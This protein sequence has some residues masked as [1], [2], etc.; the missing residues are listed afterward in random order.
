LA[1]IENPPSVGFVL[2]AAV[3]LTSAI[4]L[5]EYDVDAFLGAGEY[6]VDGPFG[7][8]CLGL[9]VP[10]P[11]PG[12][13]F[14]TLA[15]AALRRLAPY[16]RFTPST[17]AALAPPAAFLRA[18]AIPAD[19]MLSIVAWLT[20]IGAAFFDPVGFLYPEGCPPLV[21]FFMIFPY[22][23]CEV[24]FAIFLGCLTN[25]LPFAL[26]FAFA[27]FVALF[28]EGLNASQAAVGKYLFFPLDGLPSEV[29]H[30]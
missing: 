16:M 12:A 1:A 17:Y 5:G 7:P 20:F 8:T 4:G 30:F 22:R 3:F 14:F 13:A 15:C 9:T 10:E 29:F 18:A 6:D 2:E 23:Y 27:L 28:S 26:P 24:F 21:I 19:L 25:C 11:D